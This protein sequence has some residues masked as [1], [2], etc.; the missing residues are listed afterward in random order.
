M[1]RGRVDRMTACGRSPVA[2]RLG[3]LKMP[4]FDRG[5]AGGASMRSL[6]GFK[7]LDLIYF[8]LAALVI[9]T[10]GGGLYLNQFMTGL[11]GQ[12]VSMTQN[13]AAY[14]ATFLDLGDL[15]QKVNA[16]ANDIFDSQA[17]D[18]EQ[19][20]RN[21]ARAAFDQAL[22]AFREQM[23]QKKT[24]A[25]GKFVLHAIEQVADSMQSM[26]AASDAVFARFRENKFS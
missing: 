2:M 6:A 25:E 15:A 18:A 24:T 14:L 22:A 21:A 3:D 19:Q 16:P 23:A 7:N 8:A 9:A 11:Y 17:I 26:N 1:A 10:I 20:K 5:T 12:S 4:L 13:H